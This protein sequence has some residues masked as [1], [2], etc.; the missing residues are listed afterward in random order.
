MPKEFPLDPSQNAFVDLAKKGFNVVGVGEASA[1]KSVCLGEICRSLFQPNDVVLVQF[2]HL[3]DKLGPAVKPAKAFTVHS[4]F[5]LL[6]KDVT[7]ADIR[8]VLLRNSRVRS[9]VTRTHRV[10]IDE[11]LA[12]SATQVD[13]V[14]E[15]FA[16]NPYNRAGAPLS[17]T[18]SDTRRCNSFGGRQILGK[19]AHLTTG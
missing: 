9:R 11:F 3:V 12:W 13:D 19:S 1:G 5:G 16:E 7:A 14:E 6:T 18:N 17:L 15:L 2:K 10:F 8:Q 4:Y